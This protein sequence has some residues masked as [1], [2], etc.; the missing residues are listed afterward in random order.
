MS[1][2]DPLCCSLGTGKYQGPGYVEGTAWQYLFMVPHDIAGLKALLGG[3][4][5]FVGKLNCRVHRRAAA[6]TR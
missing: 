3:D 5:G 6:T 2:F 4:S 1:P